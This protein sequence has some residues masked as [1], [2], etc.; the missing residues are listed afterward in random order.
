MKKEPLSTLRLKKEMEEICIVQDDS[1]QAEYKEDGSAEIFYSHMVKEGIYEGQS[2]RFLIKTK[3]NYPF[4]P[5][6]AICLSPVFHPSIDE[7]GRICMN[8]T[9]E[10][11]SVLLGVQIVIFGISAIFYD[12]P[13]ENPLNKEAASLF[14]KDKVAYKKK[15]LEVYKRNE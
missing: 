10:D 1:I 5:P 11:W 8:V 3:E 12:V 13:E 6:K 4:S 2:Y 9:R 7:L 14:L 15:V